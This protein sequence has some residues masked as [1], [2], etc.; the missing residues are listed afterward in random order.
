MYSVTIT[1]FSVGADT[2]V[3]RGILCRPDAD[4]PFP[5]IVYAVGL[6]ATYRS[7]LPM[8]DL[9]CRNGYSLLALDFR[10]GSDESASGGDTTDMS[11]LTELR[12]FGAMVDAAS[13]LPATD[14]LVLAGESQGAL[15]AALY[16]AQH[17]ECAEAL[18]LLYPAFCLQDMLHVIFPV[19]RRIPDEYILHGYFRVGRRFAEDMYDVDPYS[20]IGRYAGPVLLLHGDRDNRVAL[21]YSE[22]AAE[23]YQNAR[24]HVMLGAGHGFEGASLREAGSEI[25]AFLD[26]VLSTQRDR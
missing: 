14:G 26:S 18:V 16:A 1:P 25:L 7:A 11:V 20:E 5:C 3:L 24:L 13:Q 8:A 17:P 19:R 6:D 2:G 12:D 9:L 4:G 21:E 10:G 15:V 23:V 22:Q